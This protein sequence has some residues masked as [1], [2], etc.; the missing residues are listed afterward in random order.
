MP[1]NHT[2]EKAAERER[3]LARLWD[4]FHRLNREHCGGTLALREIRLST[5]KQYGGYYR[6]NDSLIVISWQAHKEHGWDE[7]LNIFRHEA[8]HIA[9]PNHSRAFWNLAATF[10]CTRRYALP[11]KNR[12][13]AYCR[14]TYACP[15]CDSRVFRRK[16]L[17]KASC[18][19]CDR[20]YNPAFALRL[21]SSAAT[22]DV[23]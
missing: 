8:A 4:E 20:A 11:P 14:Y 10:G 1:K 6:K 22:R 7:T 15:V 3:V 16:R 17:V 2:T 9:H 23:A 12:T 18:G 5:R 21:V 19:K 13:H